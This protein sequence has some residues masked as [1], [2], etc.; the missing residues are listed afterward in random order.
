[1][2]DLDLLNTFIEQSANKFVPAKIDSGAINSLSLQLDAPV[3]QR[4]VFSNAVVA[5]PEEEF[6]VATPVLDDEPEEE[7]EAEP[8]PEPEAEAEPEPEPE[9]EADEEPKE[10]AK[11]KFSA[12][13]GDV[14]PGFKVSVSCANCAYFICWDYEQD[15]F[16]RKH[17][18]PCAANYT[19]NDFK[20][21]READEEAH[22]RFIE[23]VSEAREVF[24]DAAA[25]ASEEA[26]EPEN[27]EDYQ[28]VLQ[29]F[30]DATL[31]D[32]VLTLTQS[33]FSKRSI[34]AD[35][36]LDMH[37]R[38]EYKRRNGTLKGAFIEE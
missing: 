14:P 15:H 16:C 34:Y 5:E 13:Q 28:S 2:R 27:Q 1:M 24:A 10:V 23:E 12:H 22:Q 26:T 38:S 32:E 36:F 3:P 30:S 9:P 31:A 4:Q 7:L 19:C 20:S 29:K 6:F 11:Q 8:E 17:D 21:K 35:A 33:R 37:Y 25:S 18:F